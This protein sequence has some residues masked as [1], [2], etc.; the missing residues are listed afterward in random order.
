MTRA[1]FT[2]TILELCDGSIYKAWE[3]EGR[4]YYRTPESKFGPSSFDRMVEH[5]TLLCPMDAWSPASQEF[6]RRAS[7]GSRHY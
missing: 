5:L 6:F 2:H 7:S 1:E 4:W 3:F